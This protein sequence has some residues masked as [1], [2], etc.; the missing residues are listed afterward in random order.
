MKY[1]GHILIIFGLSL[2]VSPIAINRWNEIH[3]TSGS[4]SQSMVNYGTAS[5]GCARKQV[6]SIIGRLGCNNFTAAG[7]SRTRGSSAGPNF[8]QAGR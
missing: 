3:R 2:I 8:V 5:S 6:Q 1:R 7:N 4:F